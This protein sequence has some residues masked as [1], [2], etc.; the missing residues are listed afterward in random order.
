ML[1][2]SGPPD[3]FWNGRCEVCTGV[4][5]WL[6]CRFWKGPWWIGN[7]PLVVVVIV[8]V[9]WS[10]DERIYSIPVCCLHPG[11]FSFAFWCVLCRAL[12]RRFKDVM[13]AVSCRCTVTCLEIWESVPG[14]LGI[15]KGILVSCWLDFGVCTPWSAVC[16]CSTP[17]LSRKYC[18]RLPAWLNR[19]EGGACLPKLPRWSIKLVRNGPAVNICTSCSQGPDSEA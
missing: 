8:V 6:D 2:E 10:R 17:R 16:Q 12:L 7:K 14:S 5:V 9:A 4:L 15:G 11:I 18:H 1:I 19:Q 13:S 3:L